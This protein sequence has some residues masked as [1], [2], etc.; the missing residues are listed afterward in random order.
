MS[1]ADDMKRLANSA[2]KHEHGPDYWDAYALEK[3]YTRMKSE[4][5]SRARQGEL[6]GMI[7]PFFW[8]GSPVA[9]EFDTNLV[10]SRRYDEGHYMSLKKCVSATT[11]W[12]LLEYTVLCELTPAGRMVRDYISN[13][14][15][16]DGIKVSFYARYG[17]EYSEI[18]VPFKIKERD[19][20][21]DMQ[22]KTSK[23][24]DLFV[25]YEI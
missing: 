24:A 15:R 3:I 4:I 5:S 16:K 21:K 11:K 1:F 22:Y 9:K 19:L 2:P 25:R 23:Y 7:Q 6:S 13:E 14:A 17:K 18:G 20:P 8:G 10:S 12:G